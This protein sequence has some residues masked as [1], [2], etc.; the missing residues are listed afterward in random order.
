MVYIVFVTM[1]P[2][3]NC[4]SLHTRYKGL[5]FNSYSSARAYLSTRKRRAHAATK[6]APLPGSGRCAKGFGAWPPRA[7]SWHGSVVPKREAVEYCDP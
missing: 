3:W 6:D 7:M 2:K 5:A 4:K 1:P